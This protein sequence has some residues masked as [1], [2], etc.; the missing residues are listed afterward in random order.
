ME[1]TQKPQNYPIL[2]D[3]V[4]TKPSGFCHLHIPS[5]HGLL[6]IFTVMLGSDLHDLSPSHGLCLCSY[7]LQIYFLHHRQSDLLKREL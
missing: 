3:A 7:P 2:L 1:T 6:F 4:L 5:P